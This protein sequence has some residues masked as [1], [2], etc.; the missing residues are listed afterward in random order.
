MSDLALARFCRDKLPSMKPFI[1]PAALALSACAADS[2]RAPHDPV[3]RFDYG[4][5]SH[6]PFWMVAIG[7]DSVVLTMGPA[8][9]AADGELTTAAYPRA[10]PSERDGVRRWQSGEGTAVISVE[11][12]PGPCTTGGRSYPDEVTVYL[13]GRMLVGCGGQEIGEGRAG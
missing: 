4:A 3:G 13:S 10:T 8:G 6:D 9:G 11:A 5:I 7:G 1:L 12:R 2:A